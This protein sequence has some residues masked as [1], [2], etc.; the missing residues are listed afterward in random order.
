MRAPGGTRGWFL[1]ALAIVGAVTAVRVVLLAFSRADLFV[2]EAQYWL[3]GQDLAWGYYSKPP[4]IAWVIRGATEIAG[5]D[6]PFWIRLPAPLFHA[7]TALV[8]G[9]VGARL[10]GTRTAVAVAAAYATLPMVTVGS[11][12]ISTDTIMFPFL[13]AALAGY[14]ALLDA[15]AAGGRRPALALATGLALGLAFLAKYAAV[16]P[17]ALAILAALRPGLRPAPGDALLA[18]AG[19]A[20]LAA[21]NLAWNAANGMAT[22]SHTVDNT[23]WRGGIGLDLPG[24]L[25]FVAEQALVFGPILLPALV[26][27]AADG[28]VPRR[29]GLLALLSLPI[30]GLIAVQALLSGANANWA[31]SAYLAGTVLAVAWLAERPRWLAASFVINGAVALALPLL[32]T[33]ADTIRWGE[34]LVLARYVGLDELSRQILDLAEAEGARAVA[35]NERA[36]LAALFHTGRDRG[37]P[38]HAWPPEG[39]P[40]NHYEQRHAYAGGASGPVLAISRGAAAPPC[41]PLRSGRL[42]PGPGAY[43]RSRFT[44]WLVPPDCWEGRP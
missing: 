13:A 31:A 17:L 19:F 22:L 11:L 6:A 30:V 4:L 3:W 24:L 32:A 14:L 40:R 33:R 34:R 42:T 7:V 10:A 29:A 21:P 5:S 41:V 20:A 9:A 8:L 36:V 38:I 18:L 44:W 26:L 37:M 35:A 28:R 25:R 39:A 16:F 43:A 23:G 2:D 12:L 15:R 27:A 1:P